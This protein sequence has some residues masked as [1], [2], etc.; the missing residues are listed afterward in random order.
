MITPTI[1]QT[2][3]EWN[4]PLQTSQPLRGGINSQVFL[5]NQQW[6]LKQYSSLSRFNR[7]TKAFKLF[8]GLNISQ[9]PQLIQSSKNSLTSLLSYIDGQKIKIPNTNDIDQCIQFII[10]INKLTPQNTTSATD[11]CFSPSDIIMTIKKRLNNFQKH[12]TNATLH[13]FLNTKLTPVFKKIDPQLNTPKLAFEHWILSPSDIGFHN[14]IQ[15]NQQLYFFDFE[16][17]GLDDPAKFIC[18]FLLH[19]G[20]SLDQNLRQHFYQSALNWF[21]KY[22]DLGFAIQQSWQLQAIKW[23]LIILNSFLKNPLNEKI[24]LLQLAKA[25]TLLNYIIQYQHLPYPEFAIYE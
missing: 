20:M 24:C 17:F 23:C 14:A 7:E 3:A 16:Y 6:V 21:P 19:P 10:Q 1:K 11:A 9:T 25:E 5:I 18:D 12:S 13:H 2:L 4:I 22:P 15:Q 8:K